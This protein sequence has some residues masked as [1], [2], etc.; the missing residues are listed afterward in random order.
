MSQQPGRQRWLSFPAVRAGLQVTA[1]QRP[2]TGYTPPYIP[3]DPPFD[4]SKRG[5][6]KFD[7]AVRSINMVPARFV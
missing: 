3:P 2:G 4:P 6:L 7:K 1:P 5:V